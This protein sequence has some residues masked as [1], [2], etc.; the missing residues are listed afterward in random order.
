MTRP[1]LNTALNEKEFLDNYYL[2]EE[3]IAFCKQEALPSSGGKQEL[4][5]RIAYYLKTG[6]KQTAVHKQSIKEKE[7]AITL[8][9]IISV[10]ITFSQ[11]KRAFFKE[12]LGND[13]HF[14]VIFQKWMKQNTGK[15][16]RDACKAY[17]VLM[18]QKKK[19]RTSIEQ[20]FEYNT[21]I[22]DFFDH[23]KGKSLSDAICCWKYKKQ[24]S[25]SHKYESSD[26]TALTKDQK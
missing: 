21:Y 23:N 4:T 9:T 20:Q 7:T 1:E 18:Q 3:L 14:N 2:K 8:D 15:T 24:L 22:R 5:K 11:E 25:G 6:E 26:L 16:Y 19:Q 10:P 13:F 17:P 12:H